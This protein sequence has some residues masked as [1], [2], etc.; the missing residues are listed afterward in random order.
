MSLLVWVPLPFASNRIWS[1]ALLVS[2]VF[3]LLSAWLS[4]FLANRVR[5][6]GVVWRFSRLPL[7]L[8]LAVQLWAFLQLQ[9]LPSTWV[10]LLS[11]KA[12]G[13]HL[14]EGWLSISLDRE[15]GKYFLLRG[16]AYCAGFFLTIALINSYERVKIL[17]QVLVFSGTA[18][19]IYG[20]FMVLSG[21]E[22]GFFVEKYAGL[23][24]AT[25]TFVNRNHL[26]GY[27]VMCLSAGI[28]LFMSQLARDSARSW[29]DRLRRW[30]SLLLS[31]KI[32]L[33]VYLAMMVV[34]LVM[35]R[36]R[37]GNLAFFVS[38]AIAASVAIYAGR[39]ISVRMLGFIAS[40][41]VVDVLILG[42]WFGFDKLL[43]RI[44]ETNL[45]SE[46]R[47]W[48]NE[49]SLDYLADF[50]WTGSGGGSFYGIFPQYQG[51]DLVGFHQYAHNDY[52]QFAIELGLPATGLL[53]AVMILAM[54]GSYRLLQRQSPLYV[55]VGFTGAM[56]LAWAAIH[57]A[58]DFNLQI[59]ANAFT[60]VVLL[61]LIFVCR[62][63]P[64]STKSKSIKDG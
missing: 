37:T 62:G 52:L 45:G 11:P 10:E 19:A 53:L 24:L 30:L 39:Q 2:L 8:L 18:Q 48:S 12:H 4:L 5:I 7:I 3:L 14:K 54:V 64:A 63:L 47:I 42:K 32:R 26:A 38:L 51:S 27:L 58:S 21:L 29:R 34:A 61:A 22:M 60:F 49:Y 46:S 56:T 55:G 41:F 36:S 44:E 50:P 16:L 35:T 31:P 20:S 59:P 57:S 6:D 9:Y 40:L 28:G 23:G 17:L 13:W 33:R 1:G 25:G 43:A 15:S